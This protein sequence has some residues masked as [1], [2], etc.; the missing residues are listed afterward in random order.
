MEGAL[1]DLLRQLAGLRRQPD[2]EAPRL[3]RLR[4]ARRSQE[5]NEQRAE[6]QASENGRH[7]SETTSSEARQFPGSSIGER[8]VAGFATIGVLT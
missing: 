1:E 7:L 3:A 8:T 5:E 4:L 2:R 6:R